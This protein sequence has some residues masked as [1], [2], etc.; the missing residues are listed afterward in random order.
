[1]RAAALL[2]FERAEDYGLRAVEHESK[3]QREDQVCVKNLALVVDYY[4]IVPGAQFVELLK[5]GSHPFFVSVYGE[6]GVHRLAELAPDRA[7]QLAAAVAGEHRSNLR[8]VCVRRAVVDVRVLLGPHVV[9]GVL[10][11]AP[12]EDEGVEEGVRAEA[13]AAVNADAGRL[14]RGVEAW[15]V[16]E[17]V[18]VGLDAAHLV[19][20]SGTNGDRL[21]RHVCVGEVDAKLPD[22]AELL[23]DDLLSEMSHVE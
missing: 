7:E 22:L 12:T 16:G 15:H 14:A 23:V 4:L 11:G 17:T 21:V 6:V 13:V 8:L 10:A 9:G 19:V 2:P 1:M 3:L 20:H 18:N 5:G